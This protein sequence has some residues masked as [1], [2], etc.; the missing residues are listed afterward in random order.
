[1]ETV[2]VRAVVNALG[3]QFAAVE[4]AA[5]AVGV[6]LSVAWLFILLGW[7]TD[8]VGRFVEIAALTRE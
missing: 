7:L 6:A 1:M 5:V 3:Q 2:V 8:A 4:F